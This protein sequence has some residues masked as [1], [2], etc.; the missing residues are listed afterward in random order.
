MTALIFASELRAEAQNWRWQMSPDVS[1]RFDE[2]AW[3]FDEIAAGP[4]RGG[5][6]AAAIYRKLGTAVGRG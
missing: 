4:L 1:Q 5:C 6:R 2:S 3:H